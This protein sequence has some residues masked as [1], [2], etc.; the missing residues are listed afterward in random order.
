MHFDGI[1]AERLSARLLILQCV[2]SVGG[3]W[4][5]ALEIKGVAILIH[6]C[7]FKGHGDA[8]EAYTANTSY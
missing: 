7:W 8:R 3:V 1:I 4:C 2:F 5:H 6:T